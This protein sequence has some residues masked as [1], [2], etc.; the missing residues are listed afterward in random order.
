[1]YTNKAVLW[2]KSSVFSNP[3]A[4]RSQLPRPAPSCPLARQPRPAPAA[5][6]AVKVK[7]LE[8]LIIRK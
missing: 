3:A 4:H 5:S 1:M 7:T 6:Q 2:V 8:S